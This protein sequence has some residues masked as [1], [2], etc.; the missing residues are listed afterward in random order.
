MNDKNDPIG[1]YL[2]EKL[3]KVREPDPR[4][5]EPP[6]RPSPVKLASWCAAIIIV[7]AGGY[8]LS[9]RTGSGPGM[10]I[11][12]AEVMPEEPVEDDAQVAGRV[13]LVKGE[14]ALVRG[15]ERSQPSVG[16]ELHAGDVIETASE[17]SVGIEHA[18]HTV[19]LMERAR[20]SVRRAPASELRISLERGVLA[21]RSS[22]D[23]GT[24]R[25]EGKNADVVSR[26]AVFTV[27][28]AGNVLEKTSVAQ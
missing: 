3:T 13:T 21:A 12:H 14:V 25:I 26:G 28:A 19:V 15:D 10:T 4:R 24:L 20:L 1:K 9:T 5:R 27:K 6:W 23:E 16:D 7:A 18:G 22:R 8:L 11:E 2:G 17:A